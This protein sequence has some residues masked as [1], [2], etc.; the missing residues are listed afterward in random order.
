[1][2]F[3]SKLFKGHINKINEQIDTVSIII[4]MAAAKRLLDKYRKKYSEEIS[5]LL[6]AAVVNK[7]FNKEPSN[8]IGRNFLNDN[9]ELV[10][11]ELSKIKDDND[12][13]YI[14]SMVAHLKA[15]IAGNS[16]QFTDS[17]LIW[18]SKLKELDIIIP[19]DKINMPN[20]IDEL[21]EVARAF[22]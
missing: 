1:M 22:H 11:R 9:K 12:I 20:S 7:L 10:S 3:L 18:I 13:C 6:A 16:A 19:I 21:S 17:L 4:M 5:S 15:N 8:D 14:V 2:S